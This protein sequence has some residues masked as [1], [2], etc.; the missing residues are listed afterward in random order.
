MTA[1]AADALT[2]AQAA[3]IVREAMATGPLTWLYAI[4][5]GHSGPIKIGVTNAP[6]TR[7]AT[8]QQGNPDTL[9]GIAAWRGF[10]FEER[11]LH[12]EFAAV[13][14]HGEWFRPVPELV[15]LML[16]LGGNFCDWEPA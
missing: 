3:R 16:A 13:R 2:L 10:T 14:L 4:R 7:L 12:D 11:Q 1:M 6:A 8:L 9:H 15:D 5:A